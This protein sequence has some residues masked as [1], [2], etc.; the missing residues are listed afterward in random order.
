MRLF[1]N[2]QIAGNKAE[3]TPHGRNPLAQLGVFLPAAYGDVCPR[4][5]ERQSNGL[6]YP[7]AGSGNQS[8]FSIKSHLFEKHI[9]LHVSKSISGRDIGQA[10]RRRKRRIPFLQSLWTMSGSG[11][12]EH[13]ARTPAAYGPANVAAVSG[14][15]HDAVHKPERAIFSGRRRAATGQ[16][17]SGKTFRTEGNVKHGRNDTRTVLRRNALQKPA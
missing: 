7:S 14:G 4:F 8:Q 16:R 17:F 3:T 6:S 13:R 9:S 10:S 2:S 1:A 5:G 15:S 12:M 11:H